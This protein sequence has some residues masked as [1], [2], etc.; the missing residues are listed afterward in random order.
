MLGLIQMD[1]GP[2]WYHAAQTVSY[3]F[4]AHIVKNATF[5]LDIIIYDIEHVKVASKCA[6]IHLKNTTTETT[7]SVNLPRCTFTYSVFP[8]FIF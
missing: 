3:Q 2:F 8:V 6:I 1:L 4:M 7:T 5:S